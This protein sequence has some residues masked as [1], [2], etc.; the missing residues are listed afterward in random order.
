[1]EAGSFN[2]SGHQAQSQ[3]GMVHTH[4]ASVPSS[5]RAGV[6]ARLHTL[7][8]RGVEV[9]IWIL[10][11]VNIYVAWFRGSTQNTNRKLTFLSSSPEIRLAGMHGC[12]ALR[13]NSEGLT[14]S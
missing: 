13:L 4:G 6:S 9:L 3:L 8:R 2:Y 1:M 11:Y 14:V 5:C 7:L 12:I 10:E